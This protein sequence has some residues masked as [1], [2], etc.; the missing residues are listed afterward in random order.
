[1]LKGLE[2]ASI[3]AQEILDTMPEIKTSDVV[4]YFWCPYCAKKLTKE[5]VKELKCK[6]CGNYLIRDV[7]GKKLRLPKFRDE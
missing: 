2:K 1:M 4:K 7:E 5:E 6:D 3:M